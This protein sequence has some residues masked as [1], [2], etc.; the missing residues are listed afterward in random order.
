MSLSVA[1]RHS[2]AGFALDVGFA[3][4]AGVTVLF[5]HSGSGKSTVVKA[6]AGL[7]RPDA[8]RISVNGRVLLDTASR[9]SVPV[10][11]RGLGYVFQDGRLFPHMTVQGNLTYA[12]RATGD[13]FDSVVDILGLGRLLDRRPG[14]L[15]GGEA[16]RVAIGRALLSDPA[17]L[18]MDEPLAALDAPRKA[19]ILPFLDRLCSESGVPILY[20]TH[21]VAEVA[22]LANHI[23]LL[24]NGRVLRSG[25]AAQ[26]LADPALVPHMGVRDAGAL[27]NARVVA[28]HPDGLTELAGPGGPL[29][30]PGV[31][32]APG[33]RIRVRILAQDVILTRTRPKGLSAL[34]I[35]EGTIRTMH[36]GDGPGVVVQLAVDDEHLLARITRRSAE[37]L[38]LAT[39]QTCFAVL[40]SVAVS[41]VDIAEPAPNP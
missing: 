20:V 9:V 11:R 12:R 8:G 15:S 7:L 2:F 23:V 33:D 34:N 21:A 37:T 41:Q 38:E 10:H 39:G 17:M 31:S 28:H 32:R 16:Q 22:R 6:V 27:L 36:H 40:K 4:P 13:R 30:L 29:F 35:L 24:E 26:L 19:E 3:A 1:I 25:P 18:L 14:A 5:G